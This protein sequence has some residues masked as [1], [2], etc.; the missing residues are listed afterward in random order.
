MSLCGKGELIDHK[1]LSFKIEGTCNRRDGAE[2]YT[3]CVCQA[4]EK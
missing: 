1:L 3:G 4:E 2:R